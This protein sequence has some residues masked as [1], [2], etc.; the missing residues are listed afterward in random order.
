MLFWPLAD[1]C[2]QQYLL[3]QKYSGYF[4]TFSSPEKKEDALKFMHA[5]TT[6]ETHLLNA[7]DEKIIE[8]YKNNPNRGIIAQK[9]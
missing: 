2:E 5:L 8:F 9:K 1:H 3:Q 7:S 6:V 4:D